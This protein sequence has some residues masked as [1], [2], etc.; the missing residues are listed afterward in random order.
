MDVVNQQGI[1]LDNHITKIEKFNLY[2]IDMLFAQVCYNII[3][4]KI[5]DIQSFKLVIH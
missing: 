1:Y 5:I 4:N 2:A 3:E